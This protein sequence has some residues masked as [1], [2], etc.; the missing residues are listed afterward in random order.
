MFTAS[1]AIQSLDADL[2]LGKTQMGRGGLGSAGIYG[3]TLMRNNSM[4]PGS[5]GYSPVFSG[6]ANGNARVT[7]VQGNNPCTHR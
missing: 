4:R 5:L 6:T 1:R 3:L 2:L 7:L